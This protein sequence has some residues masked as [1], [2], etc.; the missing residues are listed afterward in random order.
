MSFSAQLKTAMMEREITVSE[1]AKLVG[2]GKPSISQ[3]LSGKN[4]PKVEKQERIAEVLGC[5]VEY[6]NGEAE[7]EPIGL[8]RLT[9]AQAA[10]RLGVNPQ[11]VRVALQQGTAPY[12]YAWKAKNKWAFHISPK[13]LDEYI[14]AQDTIS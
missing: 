7:E 9:P 1:L 11:A 14:G 2:I 5:T 6:L 4:I 12:G 8:Y 13:K 10:K 3:Y